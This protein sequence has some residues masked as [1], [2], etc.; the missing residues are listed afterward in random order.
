MQETVF[1]GA[2]AEDVV[3]AQ[4]V[5]VA[6]GQGLA[7]FDLLGENGIGFQGQSIGREVGQV[8]TEE[9]VKIFVPL[10]CVGSRQAINQIDADI[11]ETRL[12]GPFDAI[13]GVIGVVFSAQ[14]SQ[15]V[16][17]KA[18]DTDADAINAHV[19]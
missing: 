12:L 4:S 3:V 6:D 7:L 5:V 13:L 16:V 2:A 1:L 8:V 15:I 14:I 10:R 17:E 9:K 11:A 19:S 18:L